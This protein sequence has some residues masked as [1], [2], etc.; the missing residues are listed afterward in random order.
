MRTHEAAA[1]AV[2]LMTAA[3]TADDE[4]A[5]L[6]TRLAFT[7]VNDRVLVAFCLIEACWSWAPPTATSS[8]PV[9]GPTL[10]GLRAGDVE[11]VRSALIA[12]MTRKEA[13]SYAALLVQLACA[14]VHLI[15]DLD[16]RLQAR[17]LAIAAEPA[18]AERRR[19]GNGQ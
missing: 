1:G 9:L 15:P 8:H 19:V 14:A 2:A 6:A 3:S 17:G 18:A 7:P 12:A 10:A 4:C 13:G 16:D 5:R 11:T